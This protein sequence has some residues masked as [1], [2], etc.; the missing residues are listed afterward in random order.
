[1]KDTPS[2]SL[3]SRPREAKK[4]VTPAPGA[5]ESCDANQYK[6]KSPSFSLSTRY[7]VPSDTTLKPGPGAYTPEKVGDIAS[8]VVSFLD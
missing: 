4:Y 2:Y 5:Y 8:A 7:P 1:M 3:G 6:H